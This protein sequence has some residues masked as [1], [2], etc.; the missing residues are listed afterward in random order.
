MPRLSL[1]HGKPD[2]FGA[3]H[4]VE[5]LRWRRKPRLRTGLNERQLSGASIT[6]L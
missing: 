1:Y 4:G 2:R 5:R 6:T 3:T